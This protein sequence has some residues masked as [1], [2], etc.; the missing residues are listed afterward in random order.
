MKERGIDAGSYTV[1]SVRPA[2]VPSYLS[3]SDAGLAFI[4]PCF[5]KLASSPT[6]TAEYLGCGL[7][8][9]INAGIGDSDALITR[10]GVGALVKDFTAQ[11]YAQAAST[12]MHLAQ[13]AEQTRQRTRAIAER[14]FDVRGVGLERYARLYKNVLSQGPEV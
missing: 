13:D 14:L 10:K 5:S 11:D 4:K 2:A 6:K 9:I 8:L 7:P 3:A 12:I 1:R